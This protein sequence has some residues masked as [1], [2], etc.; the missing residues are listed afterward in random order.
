MGGFFVSLSTR[1][2]PFLGRVAE[3][4]VQLATHPVAMKYVWPAAVTSF[5][6]W[7]RKKFDMGECEAMPTA[8]APVTT[9]ATSQYQPQQPTASEKSKRADTEQDNAIRTA[10]FAV[11]SFCDWVE[12]TK[13]SVATLDMKQDIYKM[14]MA[15]EIV[16]HDEYEEVYESR[17]YEASGMA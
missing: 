8:S 16:G 5:G 4:V 11:K 7:L 6:T 3:V 13:S 12:K 14:V 2:L 10:K 17:L 1:F 15:D 9:A